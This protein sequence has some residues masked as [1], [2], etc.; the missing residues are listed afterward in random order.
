M[1][2]R[3]AVRMRQKDLAASLKGPDQPKWGHQRQ[4]WP[5]VNEDVNKERWV[6]TPTRREPGS[7]QG[8]PCRGSHA[9]GGLTSGCEGRGVSRPP[10]D[11]GGAA[12]Y[13][14]TAPVPLVTS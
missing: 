8:H 4:P 9:G 13:L 12:M 1:V 10:A 5:V 11:T 14:V 3:E 7:L 6:M 2:A